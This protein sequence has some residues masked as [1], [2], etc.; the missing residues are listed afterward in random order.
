MSE[1]STTRGL[2]LRDGVWQQR[3]NVTSK[4]LGAKPIVHWAIGSERGQSIGYVPHA[5]DRMATA[6]TGSCLIP[7]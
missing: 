6:R 7:R 4:S 1:A 5:R 3:R 2:D